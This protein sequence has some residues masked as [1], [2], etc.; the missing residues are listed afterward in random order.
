MNK[1]IS[2]IFAIAALVCAASACDA[3][4]PSL[5]YQAENFTIGQVQL[6]SGL[7]EKQRDAIGTLLNNMV[8]VEHCQ[9]LMGAQSRTSARANYLSAYSSN[10]DSL[11]LTGAR[12]ENGNFTYTANNAFVDYVH[13]LDKRTY[14]HYVGE[15]VYV[16]T[17]FFTQI[18]KMPK[19]TGSDNGNLWVGPVTEM[20]IPED[21]YIGQYEVTQAQWMAVMG[22]MPTGRRCIEVNAND[23]RESA[24]YAVVGLGDDYPAY[25]VWYEDA[26]KF[27]NRLNQICNMPDGQGRVFRLPTE[28]EWECAARGG[29]Y[30]RGFRYPGS[31]SYTDVAWCSVNA[32]AP[33]VGGKNFGMHVGGELLPNEL[34]IYDLAGNVSE[35]VQNTYYRYTYRDSIAN[36]TFNA[37]HLPAHANEGYVGDTLILRGGS[38]YQSAS[39]SFASGSRQEY[40]RGS[41]DAENLQSV[42]MHCGFR[43]VLAK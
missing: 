5:E 1:K 6:S 15:K 4:D 32:F 26:V 7:N 40:T 21:Y 34:G 33:A 27:C 41:L 2:Y 42:I 14:R 17:V 18:Y 38:W 31:D 28:A 39:S 24:W 43:I 3:D 10:V 35:W 23:S 19:T 37:R 30:S 29:Q 36:S 9:F 11:K 20:C 13:L 12:D 16:D 22:E 8:K 25:N